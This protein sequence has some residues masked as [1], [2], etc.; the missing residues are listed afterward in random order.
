MSREVAVRF[1]SRLPGL[2]VLLVAALLRL[3]GLGGEPLSAPEAGRAWFAWTLAQG[4]TPLPVERLRPAEPSPLLE[5]LHWFSSTLGADSDL[6]VRLPGAL[7]GLALVVVLLGLA[8]AIG[9]VRSLV[10][11]ALVA[12]DPGLIAISRRQGD[13]ALALIVGVLVLVPLLRR[14]FSAEG[15]G[16]PRLHERGWA[17]ALGLLLAMGWGTWALLPVV[18]LTLSC[19]GPAA[20]GARA[21]GAGATPLPWTLRWGFVG[22]GSGI[23]ATASFLAWPLLPDLSSGLTSFLGH[24]GSGCAEAGGG[25]SF[26]TLLA[27]DPVAFIVGPVALLFLLPGGWRGRD[28]RIG[29]LVLATVWGAGLVAGTRAAPE[30]LGFAILPLLLAIAIVCPGGLRSERK[31]SSRSLVRAA[32]AASLVFSAVLSARQLDLRELSPWRRLLAPP[33]DGQIRQ[34]AADLRGESSVFAR[35]SFAQLVAL[36]LPPW[37]DPL[38]GWYLRDLDPVWVEGPAQGAALGPVTALVTR[39]G[40]SPAGWIVRA[41]EE[42]MPIGRSYRVR[43][44]VPAPPSALDAV[45]LWCFAG[46]ERGE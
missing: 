30:A 25:A 21:S 13:L 45:T 2:G 28:R 42:A 15:A 36:D 9:R 44:P 39:D 3:A 17:F 1:G 22:L 37:P 5:T 18:L 43:A 24:F 10:L 12:V 14:W 41:A 6:A 27:A 8:P 31:R 33:A 20:V 40:G 23:G 11:A 38:L 16:T 34:L 46:G 29:A 35:Q 32:V 4:R 7:A 26:A 19:R